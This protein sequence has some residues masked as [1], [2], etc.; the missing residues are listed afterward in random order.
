[1]IIG[2]MRKH[3]TQQDWF[4]VTV[5][6]VVVIVSILLAFQIERWADELRNQSLEQ[7]Y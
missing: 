2:R 4:A 3:L 5:D 6:V 1:M 7:D